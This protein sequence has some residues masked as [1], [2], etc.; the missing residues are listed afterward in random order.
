MPTGP[1]T[2]P[3]LTAHVCICL[4]FRFPSAS[5]CAYEC[6]RVLPS[7]A[8][9]R[10]NPL[11]LCTFSL[12]ILLYTRCSNFN[13]SP[14]TLQ[15]QISLIFLHDGKERSFF[16]FLE[17][18]ITTCK[19]EKKVSNINYK[20]STIPPLRPRSQGKTTYPLHTTLRRNPSQNRVTQSG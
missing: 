5:P 20:L 2:I 6:V 1:A 18:Q 10:S 14:S 8:F 3:S 9:A 13:S 7:A 12:T 4:Y 15:E 17:S 19:G 11:P 16:T